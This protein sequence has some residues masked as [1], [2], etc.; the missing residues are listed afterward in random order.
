MSDSFSVLQ[1]HFSHHHDDTGRESHSRFCCSDLNLYVGTIRRGNRAGKSRSD[2]RSGDRLGY[3]L[4]LIK[5]AA[6]MKNMKGYGLQ[7]KICAVSCFSFQL[8]F[9][10]VPEP[11]K[12]L[13]ISNLEF[14][15]LDQRWRRSSLQSCEVKP[16]GP[17]H[18][19]YSLKMCI[20]GCSQT[21]K[22]FYK[23][24]FCVVTPG[25][26]L[27]SRNY[28]YVDVIPPYFGIVPKS[29]TINISVVLLTFWPD[30]FNVTVHAE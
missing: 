22:L 7:Y 1:T 15:E 25:C 14:P 3:H 30:R 10:R 11:A 28:L 26:S 2:V 16:T 27:Q 17:K 18:S 24:T 20:I 8:M 29:F 5:C 12:H 13:C 21:A 4:L 23:K 6:L 9:S 19:A